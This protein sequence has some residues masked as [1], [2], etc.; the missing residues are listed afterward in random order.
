M[1]G[2]RN[3]VAPGASGFTGSFYRVFWKFVSSLVTRAINKSFERVY[4]SIMEKLG[5]V[6][7]IPKGDKDPRLLSNW[8]PMNTFYKLISSVLAERLKTVLKRIV[9]HK[10]KAYIPSRFIVEVTRTTYDLFQYAKQNNLPGMIRL[11]DFQKAF[12][13]APFRFLE[14]TL[15]VFGFGPNYGKWISIL[16]KDFNAFTKVNGN[17][18]KYLL[19]NEVAG[20]VIPY[21]VSF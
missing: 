18:L 5:I 17:Y 19:L 16:L 21:L 7:I 13:S 8:R 9:G 4:L 20:R 15:E 14:L 12:D 2:T 11:I 10:Q 1:K 6:T 3:N